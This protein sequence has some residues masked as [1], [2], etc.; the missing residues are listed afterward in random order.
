MR[1]G[2][3]VHEWGGVGGIVCVRGVDVA[4]EGRWGGHVS[5]HWNCWAALTGVC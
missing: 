4:C 1:W 2:R 3:V 5:V